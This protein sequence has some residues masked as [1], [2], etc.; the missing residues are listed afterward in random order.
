MKILH[1]IKHN[2]VIILL[3]LSCVGLGILALSTALELRETRSPSPGETK[4]LTPTCSISFTLTDTSP[5]TGNQLNISPTQALITQAS[6][7]PSVT[8]T[9]TIKP[10][11]TI[12]LTPTPTKVAPTNTPTLT[13]TRTP[14]P[15]VQT[16]GISQPTNTLSPTPS[17]TKTSPTSTL[18]TSSPTPS[19][20]VIQSNTSPTAAAPDVPIA[21]G[22]I[23]TIAI[24]GLGGSL[25]AFS[26]WVRRK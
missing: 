24:T 20:A 23:P 6:I 1:T 3:V 17:P 10:T 22:I 15:Q 25:L 5:R 4:A 16:G 21:G 14:T 11:L 12:T 18:T 13:P 9:K 2:L 8:P 7:T 19:K 26:W